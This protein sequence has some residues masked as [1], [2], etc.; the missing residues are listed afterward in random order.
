MGSPVLV[1]AYPTQQP[2]PNKL[3][4]NGVSDFAQYFLR[5]SFNSVAGEKENKERIG[6]GWKGLKPTRKVILALL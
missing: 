2:R 6:S 3:P 1:R 5:T 4:K